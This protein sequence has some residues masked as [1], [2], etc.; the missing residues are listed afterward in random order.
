MAKSIHHARV[1]IRQRHIRVGRQI[2]NI[3]S[4]M[5]IDFSLTSPFGGGPPGRVKRKNQKKAS[6]GGGDVYNNDYASREEKEKIQKLGNNYSQRRRAKTPLCLPFANLPS[7]PLTSQV[8]DGTS[9]RTH[10]HFGIS[11]LFPT[12]AQNKNEVRNGFVFYGN[13]VIR[14]KSCKEKWKQNLA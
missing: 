6:G 7:H 10:V 12:L 9:H 11:F 14:A 13:R 5:H 8:R 3:P 4:F 1:L 2:V